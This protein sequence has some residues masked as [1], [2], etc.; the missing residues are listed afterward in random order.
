M[1]AVDRQFLRYVTGEDSRTTIL[2][3]G[4]TGPWPPPAELVYVKAPASGEAIL[5][6]DV[7]EHRDALLQV[8]SL[9]WQVHVI[10]LGSHSQLSDAEAERMTHVARGAEYVFDRHWVPS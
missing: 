6:E 9:D 3:V 4:W 7:P 1:S 10:K 5:T 2:Q 8:A